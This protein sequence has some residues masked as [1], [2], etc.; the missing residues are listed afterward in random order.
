ML[1]F[2]QQNINSY[3]IFSLFS[4]RKIYKET[5]SQLINFP[6]RP[7]GIFILTKNRVNVCECFHTLALSTLY[8]FILDKNA[9]TLKLFDNITAVPSPV[10]CQIFLIGGI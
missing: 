9:L 4:S 8:I 5:G 7:P 6:V 1:N 10:A 2:D 3:L